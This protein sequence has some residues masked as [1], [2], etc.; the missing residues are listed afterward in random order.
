VG[1]IGLFLSSAYSTNAYAT[2]PDASGVII[3]EL[4][5]D[6]AEVVL[7]GRI[8]KLDLTVPTKRVTIPHVDRNYS[9]WL[10]VSGRDVSLPTKTVKIRPGDFQLKRRKDG[11]EVYVAKTTVVFQSGKTNAGVMQYVR[12]G[13]AVITSVLIILVAL[14]VLSWLL[15]V[16][17]V[18]QIGRAKSQT[19]SFLTAFNQ[20]RTFTDARASAESYQQSPA[21][22]MY[23]AARSEM[24]KRSRSGGPL[25]DHVV[26][27]AQRAMERAG[28]ES[29][30]QLEHRLSFLGTVASAAPFIGLFGTVWGIMEAFGSI[31]PGHETLDA[32]APHL[33]NALIAT[34]VGLLAAIP[35]V[36]AYNMFIGKIRGI[37]I[38]LDGFADEMNNRL[39]RASSG[40]KTD[41]QPV[42]VS[43]I[44]RAENGEVP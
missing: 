25:D 22:S 12:D 9:H 24:E 2:T 21:V 27:N 37:S 3:L 34:A 11:R 30:H 19:D 8:V 16:A 39:V 32:V 14:S 40:L 18:R 41:S 28:R 35:A 17:K 20:A 4:D 26:E 43:D 23:H 36:M 44:L 7:D 15:I 6:V 33:A 31:Q 13:G 10:E 29:I 42:E 38:Q 1:L 5:V